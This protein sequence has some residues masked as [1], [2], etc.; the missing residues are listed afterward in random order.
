MSGSDYHVVRHGNGSCSVG[1]RR[2]GEVMHPVIGPEA[3]AQGL[4]VDG[5]NLRAR[6]HNQRFCIWDVGM[7][8]AANASVALKALREVPSELRIIS[9]D[10]T[11][12]ALRF[13][14]R[15]AGDFSYLTGLLPWIEELLDQRTVSFEIGRAKVSWEFREG[16]FVECSGDCA[17]P[18]AIFF[19]PWSPLKNSGMWTLRVF[20]R[21]QA[22]TNS[23]IP[24]SLATYSRA[25]CIRSALLLAGFFVGI[26]TRVGAKEEST[27][28]ANDP[29][30]LK[31]PLPPTWLDRARRSHSGRP[32]YSDHFTQEPL[33]DRMMEQLRAHTQFR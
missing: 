5:L 14:L 25:T 8:A 26:G 13:A 2:T 4:Y 29:A 15:H 33:S 31:S 24:C 32:L 7:G 6:A 9:F 21:L 10:V 30:L 27:I 28:A 12:E 20:E 18:N 22:G 19:D 16:D 11:S 23:E 17:P 3:E 1:C